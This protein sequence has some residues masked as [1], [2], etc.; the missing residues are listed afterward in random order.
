MHNLT[1]IT[2]DRTSTHRLKLRL[3]FSYCE[4]IQPDLASITDGSIS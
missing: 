2:F 3:I 1:S 4:S